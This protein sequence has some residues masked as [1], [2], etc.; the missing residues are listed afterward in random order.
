MRLSKSQIEIIKFT[1]SE[2]RDNKTIV[3]LFGS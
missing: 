3:Y 2:V 1:A